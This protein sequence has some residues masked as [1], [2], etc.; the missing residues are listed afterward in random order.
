MTSLSDAQLVQDL[1]A[2]IDELRRRLETGRGSRA[3]LEQ[4]AKQASLSLKRLVPSPTRQN[5]PSR[6]GKTSSVLQEG[7]RK[8]VRAAL[9]AG[10]APSQVAKHFRLS[11]ATVRQVL[12]ETT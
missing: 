2:L 10:V 5:K 9:L 8:A 1:A 4:A 3:E 11:P 12:E 6:S 7:Q